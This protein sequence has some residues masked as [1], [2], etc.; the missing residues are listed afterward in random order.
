MTALVGRS[1]RVTPR[2]ISS[3]AGLW[4]RSQ[5]QIAWIASVGVV[6][7]AARSKR[8]RIDWIMV[9]Q[10]LWKRGGMAEG[11]EGHSGQVLVAIRE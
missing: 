6:K 9:Y 5:V 2:L 7:W 10:E 4:P 1:S 3:T 8:V 11:L